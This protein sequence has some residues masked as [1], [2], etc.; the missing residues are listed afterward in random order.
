VPRL[1][2]GDGECKDDIMSSQVEDID[3]PV[4]VKNI[5]MTDRWVKFTLL[6]L[7]YPLAKGN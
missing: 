3:A 5:S 7:E 1:T 2:P 4:A 6:Q